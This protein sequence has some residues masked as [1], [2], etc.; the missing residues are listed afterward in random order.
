ML[1]QEDIDNL[2]NGFVGIC[3]NMK[4]TICQQ[5]DSQYTLYKQQFGQ[6]KDNLGTHFQ[7]GSRWRNAG[8]HAHLLAKLQ[9]V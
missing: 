3:Q 8:T 5:L 9:Q 1:L 2:A 4:E 7:V 6:L